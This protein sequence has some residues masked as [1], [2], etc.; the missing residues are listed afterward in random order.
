M[1][2][3]RLSVLSVPDRNRRRI[4]GPV[5]FICPSR[6]SVR[7]FICPSVYLSV[8]SRDDPDNPVLRS[9]SRGEASSTFR[10]AAEHRV[11]FPRGHSE[12]RHN[13]RYDPPPMP[14][15]TVDG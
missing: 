4:I 15:I 8:R 2:P 9:L 7:P 12:F 5:P 1:D 13:P 10:A 6:L 11:S 3:S 14:K